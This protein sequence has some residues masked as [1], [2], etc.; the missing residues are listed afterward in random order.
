M[1]DAR[2]ASMSS[3]VRKDRAEIEAMQA[4]I[5]KMT[6]D[7]AETVKKLKANISRL[8]LGLYFLDSSPRLQQTNKAQSETI[9]QLENQV[10]RFVLTR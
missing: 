2:N 3:S 6:L 8:S 9:S 7:H 4:T 1:R 10:N 5:S